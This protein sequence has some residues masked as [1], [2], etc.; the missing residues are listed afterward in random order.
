MENRITENDFVKREFIGFTGNEIINF[1][2]IPKVYEK[3]DY[4]WY[5]V[6]AIE[7]ADKL[8][9]DRHLLTSELLLKYRWAIREGYQH[10]L[11]SSLKNRYDYPRNQNTI[12]GILGYIERIKKASDEEMQ[13]I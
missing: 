11:D 5:I 13:N 3:S 10:Q 9:T 7:K 12:K 4:D 1:K 8:K 2:H 6:V